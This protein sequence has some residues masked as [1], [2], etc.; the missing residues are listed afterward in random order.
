MRFDTKQRVY[1]AVVLTTR[2]SILFSVVV[3][4]ILRGG[5]FEIS[6]MIPSVVVPLCVAP[7]VSFWGVSQAYRIGELNRKLADLLKYDPL[8]K[9]HSRSY[10]FEAADGVPETQAVVLMVDADHFKM[11]NDTYGHDVG[12][13]ALQHISRLIARHCRKA[14]IVAR[15]GG[16]EFGVYLPDTDL[17][18]ALLAAERIR[19]EVSATPL[20]I[21]D[22][23]ITLSTS[24]GVALRRP[25]DRVDEVLKRA[26]TA[27]YQAKA[28]GRNR[29]CLEDSD[30]FMM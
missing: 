20:Y 8:T 18:T 7:L 22:Y 23:G 26:D 3:T 10:F 28:E 4:G 29:V 17:D 19:C 21:E 16:E 1:L 14:D 15:L 12:D 2:V 9:V 5:T 6:A 27:L 11:I 25:D 24:I 30:S 13:R